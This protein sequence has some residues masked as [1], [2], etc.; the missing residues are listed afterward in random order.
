MLT[1][2]VPKQKQAPQPWWQVIEKCI[3]LEADAR[4]SAE[5]LLDVLEKIGEKAHE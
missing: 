2:D 4:Y 3:S 1:G 5:E